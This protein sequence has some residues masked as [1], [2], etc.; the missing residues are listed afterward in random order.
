[1]TRSMAF[2]YREQP[3]DCSN[4][5]GSFERNRPFQQVG[6]F[7]SICWLPP[8]L[9]SYFGFH[10]HGGRTLRRPDAH[11]GYRAENSFDVDPSLVGLPNSCLNVPDAGDLIAG[12]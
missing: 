12:V 2:S 11:I 3:K 9:F 1:M 7:D 10:F 4:A 8:R 6:L 5:K